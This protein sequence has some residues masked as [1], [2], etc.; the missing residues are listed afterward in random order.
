MV[1]FSRHRNYKYCNIAYKK[2]VETAAAGL[3]KDFKFVDDDHW[4]IRID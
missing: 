3:G 1:A 2:F 4:Y